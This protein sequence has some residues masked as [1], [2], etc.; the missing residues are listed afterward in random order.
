MYRYV[1]ARV[2]KSGNVSIRMSDSDYGLLLV[3]EEGGSVEVRTYMYVLEYSS[4][5]TSVVTYIVRT[6]VRTMVRGRKVGMLHI[7]MAGLLLV[8]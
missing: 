6:H 1:L 5:Y 8:I 3:F 2:P 4:S 7:I